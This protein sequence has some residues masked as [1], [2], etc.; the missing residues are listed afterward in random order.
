MDDEGLVKYKINYP[1]IKP[2][3]INSQQYY[4]QDINPNFLSHDSRGQSVQ[5]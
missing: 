3:D 5:S 2:Q 4:Q 1:F